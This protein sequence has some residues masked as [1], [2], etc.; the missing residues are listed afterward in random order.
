MKNNLASIAAV[1]GVVSAIL[2][3]VSAFVRAKANDAPRHDGWGG[4]SVQDVDGNDVVRTLRKQSKWN[5]AAAITASIAAIAQV[6][7]N[8][9]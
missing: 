1:F 9:L 7:S 8:S 5:S 6:I 4:G 2:W 3:I